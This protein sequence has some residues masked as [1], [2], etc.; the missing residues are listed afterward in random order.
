MVVTFHDDEIL[1][2]LDFVIESNCFKAI[3]RKQQRNKDIFDSLAAKVCLHS[4]FAHFIHFQV[5]NNWYMALN[6]MYSWLLVHS[7]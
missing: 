5:S 1:T 2:F 6:L 4:S 7:R 3:D